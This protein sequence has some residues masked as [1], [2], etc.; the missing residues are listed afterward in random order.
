M[1]SPQ[2]RERFS[3][4]R[5]GD[6]LL[7]MF[8]EEFAPGIFM[9]EGLTR[10]VAPTSVAP[11]ARREDTLPSAQPLATWRT[12]AVVIVCGCV[13][14]ALAFGLRHARLLSHADVERQPL[15]P[16]RVRFRARGAESPVGR[17]AAG[18]RRDRRS[19]RRHPRSEPWSPALCFGPRSDGS[20]EQRGDARSVGGRAAGFRP[21]GHHLSDRA[22][23]LRQDLASGM[24]RDRRR[25]W[26]GGGLFRPI[27]VTVPTCC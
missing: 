5:E 21:L 19:V 14:A 24:A 26:H 20:F 16:R 3:W 27:L 22:R 10:S 6:I 2:E 12:P 8:P 15:G 11:A 23:G 18:R 17:G 13:I 9:S 25:P 4:G 7:F 1:R